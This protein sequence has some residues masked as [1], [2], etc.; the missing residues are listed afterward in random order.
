MNP[1]EGRHLSFPF[2]I[3][4]S[5]RTEQVMSQE[6]HVRDELVQLLLTSPGERLFLPQFGGG[7][8]RLVFE[9]VNEAT[10]SVTRSMLTNA[11]SRWLG[12]RLA[13]QALTVDVHE[14]TIDIEIKYRLPGSEE[15]RVVSFQRGLSDDNR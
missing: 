8:R 4:P 15:S 11:I 10:Q 9:G 13:L 14:E 6:E 5:G 1:R 2:R 12:H 3:G 7:A